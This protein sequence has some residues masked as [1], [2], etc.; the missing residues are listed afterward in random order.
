MRTLAKDQPA[1]GLRR[2]LRMP[3]GLLPGGVGQAEDFARAVLA[4]TEPYLT[5]DGPSTGRWY[6]TARAANRDTNS[7]RVGVRFLVS[8]HPRAGDVE[9][10]TKSSRNPVQSRPT[11]LWFATRV[12]WRLSV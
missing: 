4:E 11:A 6:A 1:A 7:M 10:G 5:L 2:W 9:A 8:R 3:R 12:F